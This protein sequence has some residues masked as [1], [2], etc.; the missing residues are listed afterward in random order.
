[1]PLRQVA[2]YTRQVRVRPEGSVPVSVHR[3]DRGHDSDTRSVAGSRFLCALCGRVYKHQRNLHRHVKYECGK[4][5]LLD[6]GHDSYTRSVAGSRF[7]CALC[8]R[9]YKHQRNLHRHVKYECGK[10]A[11]LDRGHDSDTRSVA[12]SRFLCALCGR[13]YK[14][15]RNLHRHVKYE[16]GKKALFPCPYCPHRAKQ[17]AH[18]N[19]HILFRHTVVETVSTPVP[20]SD[21]F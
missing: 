12:G 6:G 10:K 8:G 7:L 19:A 20:V 18:L 9:V 11:L 15:Q 16:C 21:R 5:A 1:M 2:R 4:K 14:H 13:V 17:K 3:L